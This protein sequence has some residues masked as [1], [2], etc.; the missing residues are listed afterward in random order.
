MAH[1]PSSKKSIRQTKKRTAR[2]LFWKKQIKDLAKKVRKLSAGKEIEEKP[3]EILSAAQI[4]LDKA[5][6]KG[7]IH[8]NKA[9]RLK[10]RWNKK[11]TQL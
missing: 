1:L 11:L 7:V 6:E 9:A 5:A 8:K 3:E 4:V 10:S 2:N